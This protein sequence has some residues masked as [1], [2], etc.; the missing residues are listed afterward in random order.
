MK[1]F[2]IS[3]FLVL[4]FSL[5]AADAGNLKGPT[6]LTAAIEQAGKENKAV[7]ILFG[8]PACGTCSALK[9]MIER[10]EVRLNPAAFVIA[11][12][13]CDNPEQSKAFYEHYKVTGKMLPFV[14]IARADGTLVA[15]RTGYGTA[16]EFNSFVLKARR[17][18]GKPQ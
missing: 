3:V 9:R 15:S 8:R 12:I 7:F 13:N 2:A 5:F 10:H 16:A 1:K 6:D 18:I 4:V 17:D 14:V 11:D